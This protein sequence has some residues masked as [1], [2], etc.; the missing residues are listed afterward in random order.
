MS[1][2]A[3]V[4]KQREFS[5]LLGKP[6]IKENHITT[7]KRKSAPHICSL[8]GIVYILMVLILCN[9]RVNGENYMRKI[10]IITQIVSKENFSNSAIVH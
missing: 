10:Y 2:H 3:L 5:R 1:S 8:F 6:H 4:K 9:L 7:H